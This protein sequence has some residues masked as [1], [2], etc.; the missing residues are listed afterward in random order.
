MN[1]R[2]VLRLSALAAQVSNA[3]GQRVNPPGRSWPDPPRKTDRSALPN[4]L[5]VCAD[6]QRFDTIEGLNNPHIHTPN[7]RRFMSES[8]TFTHAMVQNP[9]CSPSRACFL[10][11]RYPHT[12]GL[13]ANGQRIRPEEILLPRVLAN[14]GYECG[15]A[16]KLHL[17]PC[18]GGRIEDRIDDGYH[19]FWWSHDLQD[20]WPGQNM[21]HEWLRSQGVKWQD[22]KSDPAG[23][24]IDPKYTQT[25]WCSMIAQRFMREQRSFQPWMMSVN[26]FQPHHPFWPAKDFLDRYDPAQLPSPAYQPG[27]LDSKPVYQRV[28]HQGAYAGSGISFAKLDDLAHRRVTAAYYAMIEQ[29]DDEF[30]QML[31]TLGATGQAGNTIVVYMSDHGEMLGDHGFYLKGPH[32]YDCAL[33]VPLIIRWPGK[34]KA[35]L[36]S[37]ALVEMMDLMPTLLDA[38][39]IPVPE[40]VQGQSLTPL[41]TG[42]TTVHR[43]SLYAEHYDSSFLYDPP[44]MATS[45]RTRTHK[46]TMYHSL[47]TGELYD[48]EKDPGEFHNLWDHPNSRDVKEQMSALMIERMADTVDPLPVRR[49]TW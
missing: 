44:P 41:L 38:A 47:R 9:V 22:P 13:R 30:G 45:V 4:I 3:R 39:G 23:V 15:L 14:F 24:P 17:S 28:D 32:F 49:S 5:W 43:D 19:R 18:A 26:I 42:Q 31:H 35:G 37:D 11:G 16:G 40:G 29:I 33:R 36:Q 10:S 7:L 48:L 2:D 20:I 1:R 27:E 12:T 46:L 25:A 8:T 21:W 34:F 6:Q